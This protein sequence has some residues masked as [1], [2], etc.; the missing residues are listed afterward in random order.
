VVN[1]AVATQS[2]FLLQDAAEMMR[3]LSTAGCLARYSIISADRLSEILTAIVTGGTIV[4]GN[5]KGHDVFSPQFGFVEVKSRIL[6]TD[7]PLPRVSLKAGNIEKSDFFMAVR[8]TKKMEL[9]DAVGVPKTAAAVL[10]AAK[11]QAS[12]LAHIGWHDWT[13]AP[14]ARRFKDEMHRALGQ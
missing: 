14:G 10:H 9:Y 8:W 11:R 4:G 5:S 2:D 6:G 12:G 13:S 7:G 3:I 1:S